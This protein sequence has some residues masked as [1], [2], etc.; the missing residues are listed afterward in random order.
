MN[1]FEKALTKIFGSANE[2]LLKKLFPVVVQINQLEPEIKRLSDEQLR[3]KTEEFR[4][5]LVKRLDGVD[6]LPPAE[7]KQIEQA[8]LDELLP[9][10]FACVR[11]ASIRDARRRGG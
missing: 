10:A 7:R 8:A 5:R 1:A 6:E 2:R 3:A 9:E 11:E 4:A